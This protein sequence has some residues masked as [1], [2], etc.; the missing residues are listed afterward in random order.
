MGRARSYSPPK[1]LLANKL[2]EF[3]NAHDVTLACQE[4]LDQERVRPAQLDHTRYLCISNFNGKKLAQIAPLS[5]G[6]P[7]LH[8]CQT[9][10]CVCSYLRGDDD[11]DSHIR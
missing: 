8:S 6:D 10:G 1:A 7:L 9:L 3:L 11:A 2:A 5:I 4:M